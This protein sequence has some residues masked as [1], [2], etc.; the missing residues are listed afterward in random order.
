MK[1]NLI[2]TAIIVALLAGGIGF[3]GGTWYQSGKAGTGTNGDFRG[4]RGG[5]TQNRTARFGAGGRVAGEIL[6]LDD[7]SMTVKL[8]DGSSKI[9]LLSSTTMYNKASDGSKSDL[10]KGDRVAAFG[11]DNSD[12]S[13]TAT[14]VQLNPIFP[15]AGDRS[16]RGTQNQTQNRTQN[17]TQP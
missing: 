10:K 6:S 13:V 7:K 3:F 16:G 5:N 2:I 9:V 4:S 11:T 17:Q 14:N 15:M 12:G 8:Q 1:N